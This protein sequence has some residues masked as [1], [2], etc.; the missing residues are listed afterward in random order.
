MHYY[1]DFEKPVADLENKIEELKRLA[2]GRDMNITSEIKKLEKKAKDL[3]IDIFSKL[4][5]WQKT[6][7]ARHPERPHTLD[8]IRYLMKDFI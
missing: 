3:R 4:T 6:L 1:L 2:D 5:P 8:Y 7:L